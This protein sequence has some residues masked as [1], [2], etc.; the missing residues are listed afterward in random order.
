MLRSHRNAENKA[1]KRSGT[2]E[3]VT[4]LDKLLNDA[5]EEIKVRDESTEKKRNTKADKEKKLINDGEHARMVAMTRPSRRLERDVEGPDLSNSDKPAKRQKKWRPPSASG[6]DY[7]E[8]TLKTLE[9]SKMKIENRRL[10]LEEKRIADAADA[11]AAENKRYEA[12]LELRRQQAQKAAEVNASLLK[13]LS[14]LTKPGGSS[15]LVFRVSRA[16]WL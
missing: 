15:N 6:E 10:D 12:E 1:R 5:D 4:H 14:S 3:E 7:L 2:S 16:P 13:V 9:E 11:R 8:D